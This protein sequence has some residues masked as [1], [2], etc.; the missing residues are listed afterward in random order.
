MPKEWNLSN[1]P[2][3]NDSRIILKEIPERRFF[4]ER[5][6]GGWSDELYNQELN[7]LKTEAIK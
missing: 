3:S 6:V 2:K 1:L 5:Y 7:R 4:A